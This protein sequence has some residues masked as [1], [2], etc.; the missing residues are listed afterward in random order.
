LH[1][2]AS[3]ERVG[4]FGKGVSHNEFQLPGLIPARGQPEEIVALDVHPRPAQG[5]TEPG[6][7]FDGCLPAG[8]PSSWKPG[9][10]HD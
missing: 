1:S 2:A 3:Y 4:T 7:K 10:I 6:S 8:I 5:I 9:Q